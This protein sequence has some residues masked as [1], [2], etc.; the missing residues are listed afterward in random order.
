MSRIHRR[1]FL[2]GIAATGLLTTSPLWLRQAFAGE[3]DCSTSLHSLVTLGAA[4]RRAHAAGHR[5]LVLIM[6]ADPGERFS[7]GELLGAF[8]NH[9]TDEELAPL[10]LCELACATLQDLR[11]LVPNAPTKEPLMVL[12]D[13]SALGRPAVAIE[14]VLPRFEW[15]T[16]PEPSRDTDW[17]KVARLRAAREDVEWSGR[18]H[19]VAR[20]VRLAVA[21]GLAFANEAMA[22]ARVRSRWVDAPVPGSYWAQSSGCGTTIEGFETEGEMMMA[23]GMGQVPEKARRFLYLFSN[24][25]AHYRRSAP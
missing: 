3:S 11:T 24:L 18:I 2:G 8:L 12:V 17:A 9:G 25:P 22:A 10:S 4:F 14:P 19:A 13:P 15:P 7:R 16:L 20:A 23:C 21:P 5:L 1:G 6:P